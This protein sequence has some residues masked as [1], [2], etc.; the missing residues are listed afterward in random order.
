MEKVD[1]VEGNLLP[2]GG[3]GLTHLPEAFQEPPSQGDRTHGGQSG[4]EAGEQTGAHS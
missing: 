4:R 1:E 3:E 2:E